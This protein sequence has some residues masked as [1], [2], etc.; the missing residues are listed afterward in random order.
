VS[1]PGNPELLSDQDTGALVYQVIVEDDLAYV[2]AGN[3]GLLIY[4]VSDPAAP[5]P[6]GSLALPFCTGV[7]F[8]NDHV[9]LTKPSTNS[10]LF[11]VDVSN[12]VAPL[13]VATVP[14]PDR[15]YRATVHAGTV[16]ATKGS[17][18]GTAIVDISSPSE[19]KLLYHRVFPV[20]TNGAVASGEV[21]FV[22]ASP[23]LAIMPLQCPSASGVDQTMPPP[24]LL[25]LGQNE[26]NPFNPLTTIRYDLAHPQQVSLRVYDM[27]G[28][29]VRTL[30]GNQWHEAGPHAVNWAGRD[31]D[32]R[33]V[34]AGVYRYSLEGEGFR[35]S[36]SML[37]LK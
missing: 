25:R 26:P 29:L 16:Y 22:G 35:E 34:A 10:D 24:V 18:T 11:V 31:S 21:L 1:D 5:V 8:E 28:R 2:A 30:V 12:P 23:G 32:G 9:F 36:R 33:I 7:A 6:V 19:A 37:L 15:F 4:D 3:G 20:W 17:S 13:L 14:L 27:A